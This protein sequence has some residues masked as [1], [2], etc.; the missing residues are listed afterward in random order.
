M[1]RIFEEFH[2]VG[3]TVDRVHIRNATDWSPDT[4]IDTYFDRCDAASGYKPT[5]S[6]PMSDDPR[7]YN[8]SL[9][10]TM[11]HRNVAEA[12]ANLAQELD[13]DIKRHKLEISRQSPI[14]L[15]CYWSAFDHNGRRK[16]ADWFKK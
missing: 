12:K 11:I 16:T 7:Y 4:M 10:V 13:A 15:D 8:G 5:R 6:A 3:G 2:T 1:P 9:Y 14:P